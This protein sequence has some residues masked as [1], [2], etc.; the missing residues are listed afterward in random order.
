MFQSGLMLEMFVYR[1]SQM[2]VSIVQPFF[3]CIG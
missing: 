3:D 2:Y 1:T